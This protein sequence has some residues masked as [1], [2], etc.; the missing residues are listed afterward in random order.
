M[1]D[2]EIRALGEIA[3]RA[4][5]RPSVLARDVHGAVTSRVFGALGPFGAP[6]RMVHDTVSNVSYRGVGAALRAP[7][8]A[9][10]RALSEAAGSSSRSLADT[11]LGALGLGAANGVFGDRL[12]RDHPDLSLDLT[13]RDRGRAVPLDSD[14]I[15]AAFTEATPK[16]AVFV[17]GLCGTEHT[18]GWRAPGADASP[19]YGAALR[20]GL[21]Y[22]P[23]YVRYNTGLHVSDNGRRLASTIERLVAHWPTEVES[24]ALLGH[25]MGGLVSRSACHY[26]EAEGHAWT[27][28]V[29]HVICLGTPHLGAP[30]EKAANVAGWAFTRLPETRP[31]GDFFLNHRSAGIKDLRFGNCVEEDWCDCEPDEFLRD[32]CREL[33]FLECATYCFVAA[34]LSPQPEGMGGRIGDLLVTYTSATGAG[35][36]RRLPFAAENGAHVGGIDHMRLLNHPAVHVQIRDWLDRSQFESAT[37]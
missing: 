2:G 11:P 13:I 3:G 35:R 37:P 16:L 7:L 33:P 15:A 17:H 19:T 31:F 14:G 1:R 9:G 23:I 32:R 21:G 36:R 20:E 27:G 24:V 28:R 5:A 26:G 29:S 6:V 12:A 25:S 8:Q 4:I 10:G 34:T 30:L 22:T 18:W